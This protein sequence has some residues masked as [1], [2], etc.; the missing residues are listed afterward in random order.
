M[1]GHIRRSIQVNVNHQIPFIKRH[2]LERF[3]PQD[4]GVIDQDIDGAIFLDRSLDDTFSAFPVRYGILV[5]DSL[6]TGRSYLFHDQISSIT[7][8][9]PIHRSTQVVNNYFYTQIRQ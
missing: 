9:R 2:L 7:L 1:P 6:A 3:I 5:S 8:A 4:T